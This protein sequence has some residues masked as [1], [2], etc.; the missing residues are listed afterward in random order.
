MDK[1]ASDVTVLGDFGKC[2]GDE[3]LS[4]FRK[5]WK[6]EYISGDFDNCARRDYLTWFLDIE[7]NNA[8]STT[9]TMQPN[10]RARNFFFS[11]FFFPRAVFF[12]NF[13]GYITDCW[14]RHD[15]TIN[16]MVFHTLFFARQMKSGQMIFSDL[17]SQ[18]SRQTMSFDAKCQFLHFRLWW[19]KTKIASNGIILRDSRK[20]SSNDIVWRDS[21]KDVRNMQNTW[22]PKI[23]RATMHMHNNEKYNNDRCIR[24]RAFF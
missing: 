12:C 5:M 1:I 20:S 24:V 11:R 2:V 13:A 7:Y 18:E 21:Q 17:I 3:I 9:M 23:V 19:W 22:S 6:I 14:H 4:V 15:L 10:T 16:V 8:T